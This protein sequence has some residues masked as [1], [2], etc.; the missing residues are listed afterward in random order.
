MTLWKLSLIAL[1]L[2]FAVNAELS[3]NKTEQL[4]LNTFEN[5]KATKRVP[6]SYP[7]KLAKDGIEGWVKLSYAVD[8]D[9]SVSNVVVEQSSHRLFEK[10]T[11]KAIKKWKFTPATLDGK[12]IQQCLN[13]MTMDF[14]LHGANAGSDFMNEV[15]GVITDIRANEIESANSK[16]Q[17]LKEEKNFSFH[18]QYLVH[19]A[20]SELAAKNGDKKAEYEALISALNTDPNLTSDAKISVL[21][22]TFIAAVNTMQY[23]KALSIFDDLKNIPAS[24]EIV[25]RLQSTQQQVS[26]F[27]ASDQPFPTD[28][29]V[30]ERGT[31]HHPLS[32]SSF[33]LTGN[34]DDLSTLDIRCERKLSQFKVAPDVTWDIPES[35]GNCSLVVHGDAN[36]A[37]TVVELNKA[38]TEA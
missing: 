15:S 27:L 19:I 6:P 2:P 24:D 23:A 38:K 18:K 3:D 10:E 33:S 14:K 29:T 28:M 1:A 22:K 32:R 11:I 12:P 37:F 31:V 21:A 36:T 17:K 30:T 34:L 26:D 16:L 13:N 25:A 4:H 20:E 5:A 7:K 8:E 9:G 35:W